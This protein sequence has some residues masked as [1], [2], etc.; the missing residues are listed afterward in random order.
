LFM[1]KMI[2]RLAQFEKLYMAAFAP[3][4]KVAIY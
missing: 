1:T 4:I 2:T 3:I